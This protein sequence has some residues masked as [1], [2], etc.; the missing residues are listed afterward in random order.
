M[1]LLYLLVGLD[2]GAFAA[3]FIASFK[4]KGE[5]SRVEERTKILETQNKEIIAQQEEIQSMNDQLEEV[6]HQRTKRLEE[7]NRLL[8][9]YAFFNAHKV[10][11][12]L[13]R[14]LGLLNLYKD[15]HES[16][17]SFLF[18]NIEMSAKEFLPAAKYARPLRIRMLPQIGHADSG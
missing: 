17:I 18:S 15:G 5:V 7:K 4:Y 3:W 11:G 12:P 16:H 1:E 8:T 13:A 10:R 2:V 9:E 6:I 14:I